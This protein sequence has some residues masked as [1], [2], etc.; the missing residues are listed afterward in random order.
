[1]TILKSVNVHDAVKHIDNRRQRKGLHKTAEESFWF[2]YPTVDC[3]DKSYG[4]HMHA[5][6][7]DCHDTCIFLFYGL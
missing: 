7:L 1:M 2:S 4:M 3:F 6:A 5:K